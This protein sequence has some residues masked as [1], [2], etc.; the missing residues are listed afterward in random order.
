VLV[1][2]IYNEAGEKVALV[3][4]A[5]ISRDIDDIVMTVDG[6]ESN[7]FNPGES[8]LKFEFPGIK[9]TG[10]GDEDASFEWAGINDNGQSIGQGIYYAKIAVQDPYGHVETRVKEIHLVEQESY[11]RVTV[12]NA[13]GEVV[14]VIKRENPP[15]TIIN[16]GAQNVFV[17]GENQ[18]V[19][20]VYGAGGEFVE[21]DGKNLEGSLVSNGVYQLQ[22]DVV[23]K[24]GYTVGGSKAITI[25]N[26][27][28]DEILGSVKAY[29]NPVVIDKYNYGYPVTVSWTGLYPGKVK[30]RIYNMAGEIV[31]KL[32]SGMQAGSVVWDLT[33]EAGEKASSGF[34]VAVITGMR[35]TGEF[36]FKKIKLAVIKQHNPDF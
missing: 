1:I 17:V 6:E 18:D 22:V 3:T 8:A 13:A 20:F 16:M 28:S 11:V 24:A 27:E 5:L 4:D 30:V 31:K 29:P 32:E 35:D 15:T 36:E 7:V 21:W 23:T 9:V 12:Y 2:E 33:T 26:L 14:N 25:I 10:Q 34:Y 19:K